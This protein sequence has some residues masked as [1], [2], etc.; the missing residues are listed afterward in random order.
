MTEEREIRLGGG[1]FARLTGAMD[2]N[3]ELMEK[4]FGVRITASAEGLR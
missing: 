4:R 3:L 1:V 2:G